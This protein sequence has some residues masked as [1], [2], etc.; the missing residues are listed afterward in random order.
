LQDLAELVPGLGQPIL[1]T[2]SGSKRRALDHARVL[3]LVQTLRQERAR[4][5]RHPAAD[6]VESSGTGEQLAPDQRRP[7]LGADLA[8][9]GYRAELTIALHGLDCSHPPG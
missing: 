3:Q 7:S 9:Y 5:Q 2:A 6:L 8:S 4:D 1:P